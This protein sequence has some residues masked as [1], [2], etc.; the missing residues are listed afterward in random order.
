MFL[1]DEAGR[2]Q[3]LPHSVY[4]ALARAEALVPAFAG[5]EFRLADWYVRHT[6]GGAPEVLSEWYGWVQFDQDGAFD[7][8]GWPGGEDT[9]CALG[10]RWMPLRYAARKNV[11]GCRKPSCRLA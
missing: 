10:G 7:P 6:N 8:T 2:V 9:G 5:R 3:L 1:L 4:V 11:L